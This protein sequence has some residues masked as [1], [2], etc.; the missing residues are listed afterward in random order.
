MIRIRAEPEFNLDSLRALS[1]YNC[2]F[3]GPTFE[4]TGF[5]DAVLRAPTAEITKLLECMLKGSQAT[6]KRGLGICLPSRKQA[7]KLAG[8]F[9]VRH[10]EIES[11]WDRFVRDQTILDVVEVLVRVV[12]AVVKRREEF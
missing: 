6:V 3:F 12:C 4:Q 11:L 2:N 8:R 1:T 9:G 7:H 10:H 5:L